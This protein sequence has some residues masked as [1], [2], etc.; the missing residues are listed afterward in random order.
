MKKKFNIR[1][2]NEVGEDIQY[3]LQQFKKEA[4]KKAEEIFGES[5]S[6]AT[7]VPDDNDVEHFDMKNMYKANKAKPKAE[8]DAI[9]NNLKGGIGANKNGITTNCFRNF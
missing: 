7:N 8:K 4:M 2:D 3:Y 9:D 6:A 5:E 1:Y